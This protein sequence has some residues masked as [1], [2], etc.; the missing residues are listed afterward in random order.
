MQS[1]AVSCRQNA[2][3]KRRVYCCDAT[4][5]LYE[6]YYSRQNGG[7]IP[8]FAGGSPSPPFPSHSSFPFPS[9]VPSHILSHPSPLPFPIPSPPPPCH[10]A[11]P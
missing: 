11:A 2:D 7:E 1:A 10:E 8:V 5:D 4:R 3:M 6:D 9:P